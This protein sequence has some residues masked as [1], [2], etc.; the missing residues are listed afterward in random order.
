MEIVKQLLEI[1]T[2]KERKQAGFLLVMVLIMAFIDVIGVASI[3]PFMSVLTNPQLIE[4]NYYLNSLFKILGADNHQQFQFILGLMVFTLLVTSLAVNALTTYLQ[5]RFVMM[6]E[7]TVSKRLIEG[8]LYQPYIWFLDR[9]STDLGKTILSEINHVISHAAVP[10]MNV[11]AQVLVTLSLLTLLIIIDPML[12]ISVGFTLGAVYILIFKI[13]MGYLV[14]IG[15][16]RLV[17]NKQRYS[18][19]SEA[20][21]AAKEVKV[22]GL[23]QIFVNRYAEPAEKYAKYDASAHLISQIPRFA[24][25]AIAFG[26]LILIILYLMYQ[27]NNF[28]SVLP[29]VSLYALAGYKLLPALQKIYSAISL[30]RYSGSS[31]SNL[32]QEVKSLEP[33]SLQ[34]DSTSINI[35]KNIE[36][37]NISFSY[38]NSPNKILK[39]ISLTIPVNTN[40]GFVG[41]SGSGKTTIVDLIL[42]LLEARE[43]TLQVDGKIISKSN[44]RSWQKIVGYVPQQIYLSDDTIYANIAFGI[45]SEEI[46]HNLVQRAA[47][48]ANLHEFIIDNLKSG[49]ET[50]IGERGVKLSGGQRQRIGIARA[51]YFKPQ[52]LILDEATS[53]LDNLTEEGVMES[54]H[55]LTNEITI[56][57]IAHRLSTLKECDTIFFLDKGEIKDKGSFETLIKNNKKFRDLAEAM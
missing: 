30:L 19:V 38:P 53:A 23:E 51:L 40:V 21:G 17:A 44:R 13:T 3:M 34:A 14:D 12:A 52:V 43:G 1:L 28:A 39:N 22:R 10:I 54:V 57:M 32:Y 27:S 55:S 25:E 29:I 4:T 48:I 37:K 45:P 6:R 16:N 24:I 15:R 33:Y 11:I 18:A 46:D 50:K 9:H 31:L 20:F 5:L 35:N 56:I 42:G 47:K 36:L 8:Y 26:G 2:A 41:S 49:Y 7:Y